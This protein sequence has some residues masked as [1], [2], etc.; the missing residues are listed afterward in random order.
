MPPCWRRWGNR[1]PPSEG[2]SVVNPTTQQSNSPT[3]Q[4]AQAHGRAP[5]RQDETATG[6]P[7]AWRAGC[8]TAW[9]G[10]RPGMRCLGHPCGSVSRHPAADGGGRTRTWRPSG[11]AGE[12]PH[13]RPVRSAT[14]RACPKG[15]RMRGRQ[16]RDHPPDASG[17]P[18]DLGDTPQASAHRLPCSR[19]GASLSTGRGA[20]RESLAGSDVI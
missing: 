13:L 1:A 16:R 5:M 4:Q 9:T 18:L 15:G 19:Q 14:R 2:R 8:R 20:G 12:A 10:E 3:I 6:A 11:P 17:V 7:P